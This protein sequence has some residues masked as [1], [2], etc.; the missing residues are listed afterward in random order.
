MPS[1]LCASAQ[2]LW[3][4]TVTRWEVD[5]AAALSHLANACR[6]LTRLGELERILAKEGTLIL[7]RFRQPAAHPA[8]KLMVSEGRNFRECMAALQLDIESLYLEEE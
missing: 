4:D 3:T 8:H 5:D 1:G 2:K 6:S 7:N